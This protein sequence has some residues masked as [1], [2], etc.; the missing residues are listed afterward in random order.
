MRAA[1]LKLAAAIALLVGLLSL[2]GDWG[3]LQR[4]RERSVPAPALEGAARR[5]E[6]GPSDRSLWR[7]LALAG[8]LEMGLAG[9]LAYTLSGLLLRRLE[10][11]Q[12]GVAAIAAG[13]EGRL[14][15][16]RGPD[17]LA[18]LARAIEEMGEQLRSRLREVSAEKERLQAMLQ[19]MVEGVLVLD[20][21][22]KVVLANPPLSELLGA[23]G[24]VRGRRALELIRRTELAE[25]L[26]RAAHSEEPVV[27]EL[28]LGVERDRQVQMHAVR[29]PAQGA[30]LGTVAVFHD[31]TELR[32]LE[33]VRREFVANVSHE[34]K[35]PLTAI[36][37]F[38]E[39]LH[40]GAVPEARRRHYLEVI[41]RHAERLGALIDDLLELS[42]IEAGESPLEL[43]DLPV[44]ELAGDLLR[45]LEPRFEALRIQVRLETAGEGTARADR[46]ALRQVLQ[47]LLDNAAKYGGPDGEVVLRVREEPALVCIEVCD[48]GIGISERE[49][50]RIF[51]RFYRADAA[52]AR[53]PGGTG[54]GLAIVKHLM[55]SM[56]G[57]V[58]V[59][60]QEGRGSTFRLRLPRA[61]SPAGQRS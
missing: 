32:R 19:G 27:R 43:G 53:D 35:T 11:L 6:R 46:R 20:A 9:V 51:E 58:E 36:Q 14:L 2:V 57:S 34:L 37:G 5:H 12:Q 42:R 21:E 45:D 52:R 47:N 24:E 48:R 1:R 22:G 33:G 49:R 31:V 55:Q 40:E 26:E 7:S 3:L 39:T 17:P 54:L 23:W 60:S 30:L 59:E 25:A 50:G 13:E 8:A 28:R 38:A 4:L 16:L 56:G 18:A 61:E 10:E 41:L 44:A 29:V 15:S